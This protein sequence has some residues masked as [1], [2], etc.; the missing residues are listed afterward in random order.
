MLINPEVKSEY[1]EDSSKL[2]IPLYSLGKNIPLNTKL[3]PEYSEE[4]LKLNI[5]FYFLKN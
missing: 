4:S 5:P 2:Y 3:K 1:S